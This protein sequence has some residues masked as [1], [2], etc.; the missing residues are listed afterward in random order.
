LDT[1]HATLP[2]RADSNSDG[3]EI[4]ASVNNAI[5]SGER[6]PL[7]PSLSPTL[8]VQ[9]ASPPIVASTEPILTLV[10]LTDDDADNGDDGAGNVSNSSDSDGTEESDEEVD[11][12]E[13]TDSETEH[14]KSEDKIDPN[15]ADVRPKNL[16]P[17]KSVGEDTGNQTSTGHS[18]PEIDI[19]ACIDPVATGITKEE[20]KAAMDDMRKQEQAEQQEQRLR[21]ENHDHDGSLGALGMGMGIN[22]RASNTGVDH[23]G[24]PFL[25]EIVLSSPSSA[26]V[27]NDAGVVNDAAGQTRQGQDHSG[28]SDVDPPYV[29]QSP[30]SRTGR[31]SSDSDECH[32]LSSFLDGSR[33]NFESDLHHHRLD[34]RHHSS[35]ENVDEN[36]EAESRVGRNED[37]DI[38]MVYS[39][40]DVDVGRD[41]GIGGQLL[42]KTVNERVSA[43]AMDV[44]GINDSPEP[45]PWHGRNH[46]HIHDAYG[47]GNC[48]GQYSSPSLDWSPSL[49]T[50]ERYHRHSH[51]RHHGLFDED[52]EDG[53]HML[54]HRHTC[55]QHHPSQWSIMI[56]LFDFF[57][58]FT[59]IVSFSHLLHL[60]TCL[61]PKSYS[62]PLL[63]GALG[64]G[65]DAFMKKKTPIWLLLRSLAP[66]VS[67]WLSRHLL[68]IA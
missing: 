2:T 44:D 26:L 38:K 34:R 16:V 8:P 5:G 30:G 18:I 32:S 35:Y 25:N 21:Q 42:E 43:N 57:L 54:Q 17:I 19:E 60:L 15:P 50:L 39:V 1:C 11:Q 27:G 51:S 3:N 40:V 10:T 63:S 49:F 12:L 33:D 29:H 56:F 6:I 62:F 55:H 13:S 31:Q 68:H 23:G 58:P 24:L 66:L 14:V 36:E 9:L 45:N 52:E 47:G 65:D 41:V 64:A 48:G 4:A 28:S 61:V 20:V 46:L 37:L 67:I 59:E 53:E 22:I 7:T